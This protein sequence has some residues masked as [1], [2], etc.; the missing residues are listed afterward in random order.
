MSNPHSS[1]QS[2]FGLLQAEAAPDNQFVWKAGFPLEHPLFS[3][4]VPVYLLT[5]AERLSPEMLR[6]T[7]EIV[8]RAGEY[9]EKSL[10]FIQQTLAGDPDKYNITAAERPWLDLPVSEFPLEFPQF[11]FYESEEWLMHFAGGRF[12]I[13]DP[14]GI[15]VSYRSTVP[16]SVENLEDSD[17]ME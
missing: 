6:F 9:I 17:P 16:V 3:G 4:T 2:P 5:A 8:A 14:Y 13:C 12:Q 11:T 10:L 7:E 15:A 1:Y